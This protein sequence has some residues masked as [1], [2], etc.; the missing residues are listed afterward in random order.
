MREIRPYGSVRGARSNARPYRDSRMQIALRA[1]RFES[2]LRGPRRPRF[3]LRV[4]IL[5]E[6]RTAHLSPVVGSNGGFKRL[7]W[8]HVTDVCKISHTAN[9]FLADASVDRVG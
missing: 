7:P 5:P 8:E 6:L 4:K 2:L 9:Y 1:K 3:V